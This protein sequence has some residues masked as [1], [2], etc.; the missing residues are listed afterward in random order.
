MNSSYNGQTNIIIQQH[1][2]IDDSFCS[3]TE[4]EIPSISSNSNMQIASNGSGKNIS[5]TINNIIQPENHINRNSILH[6][7]HN[8]QNIYGI[9]NSF[10]SPYHH[11][12]EYQNNN[13]TPS[14][15]NNVELQYTYVD[16]NPTSNDN[17]MT[18]N[19]ITNPRILHNSSSQQ[20]ILTSPVEESSSIIQKYETSR[21][22]ISVNRNNTINGS[23]TIT[24]DIDGN[25]HHQVSNS[26]YVTATSRSHV[27]S[28]PTYY[29]DT[30]KNSSI[31]STSINGNQIVYRSPTT[32]CNINQNSKHSGII[33][34]RKNVSLK[35]LNSIPIHNGGQQP[36]IIHNICSGEN[37]F[38]IT[39]TRS[40][41]NNYEETQQSISHESE[42]ILRSNIHKTILS[43]DNKVGRMQYVSFSSPESDILINNR[44][45]NSQKTSHNNNT[46]KEIINYVGDKQ[47]VEK[48][49]TREE[50]S[51]IISKNFCRNGKYIQNSCTFNDDH[52][53][54]DLTKQQKLEAKRAKQAE[55]ARKRYHNL[56]EEEKKELNKKR[57]LAQKM[58]RQRDKEMM[59]LDNILRQSNDIVEDPEINK[60]LKSKKMRARW[61][62]AARARYHRMTPE[63]KKAYNLKRRMKQLA[64]NV[65]DNDKIS[66]E[67]KQKI[68]QKN[69]KEQNARKAEAARLRYHAMTDEQKRAYNR[70]RTEALR[71]KRDEEEKLLSIPVKNITKDTWEKAQ[72]ILT[73]NER[74]AAAARLRYQKMTPEERR[75]YNRRKP[76]HKD[77]KDNEH[78]HLE[79]FIDD[80]SSYGEHSDK[81]LSMSSSVDYN[82]EENDILSNI[83]RDVIRRTHIAK[84]T[85]I[86]QNNDNIKNTIEKEKNNHSVNIISDSSNFV[87]HIHHPC[88]SQLILN[89]L[90]TNSMTNGNIV[91]S[92][93]DLVQILPES[94]SIESNVVENYQSSPISSQT[95]NHGESNLMDL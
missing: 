38:N 72:K 4:D 40:S 25:N 62:E 92:Q 42:S 11:F 93:D 78:Y 17:I 36:R 63:E 29:L 3:G 84:Q 79:N 37:T 74:R 80:Q 82:L 59:E 24:S 46:A 83:E 76:K 10:H 57:T 32:V 14:T 44:S 75:L 6:Q 28:A 56:S 9:S 73:R 86:R 12:S 45:D 71:K 39:D 95:Y 58:K 26:N 77:S 31:A 18:L 54:E 41:N 49:V 13:S 89:D 15:S 60:V 61:A 27:S 5:S 87:T 51:N 1:S 90:T 70:K 69:L 47:N 21:K 33:G 65:L 43:N 19:T 67:E 8:N 48:L 50:N 53:K 64:S 55:V 23:L 52:K 35:N 88:E 2:Y 34:I 30:I 68:L 7:S 94:P 85:L 91:Y 16:S 20:I 66:P 81:T 22:I